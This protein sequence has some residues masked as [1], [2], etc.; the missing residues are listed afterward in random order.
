MVCSHVCGTVKYSFPGSLPLQVNL[1]HVK[2][3]MEMGLHV[4]NTVSEDNLYGQSHGFDCNFG[5][6]CMSSRQGSAI[7]PIVKCN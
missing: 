6:N 7:L 5:N 1:E 3:C 2:A 4:D